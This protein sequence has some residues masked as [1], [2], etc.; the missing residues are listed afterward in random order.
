[1]KIVWGFCGY[2]FS[3]EVKMVEEKLTD[4]SKRVKLDVAEEQLS[5]KKKK[6]T[7]EEEEERE[8]VEEEENGGDEDEEEEDEEMRII[9]EEYKV[10]KKNAPFLYDVC[11]KHNLSSAAPLTCQW[12]PPKTQVESDYSAHELLLGTKRGESSAKCLSIVKAFLPNDSAELQVKEFDG[13]ELGGYANNVSK[14]NPMIEIVHDGDVNRARFMPSDYFI[15]A[16][17]MGLDIGVFKFDEMESK[18]KDDTCRP[19][20]KGVGHSEEGYGLDWSQRLQNYLLSCGMDGTFVWNVDRQ[21]VTNG[22]ITPV[23][24][25]NESAADCAWNPHQADTFATVSLDGRASF[26]DI[27]EK[28]CI[29]DI[30]SSMGDLN[31][32]SFNPRKEN[33]F[34]TG[35]ASKN[36]Q[37]WD[38]RKIGDKSAKDSKPQHEL[39]GHTGEIYGLQWAPF[40]ENILAS[41]GDDRRVML[42][43][44]ER[45]GR[46]QTAEEAEDGEPELLFIHGGH[47]SRV[48][49]VS[50]NPNDEWVLASVADNGED[51]DLQIWQPAEHIYNEEA[52]DDDEEDDDDLE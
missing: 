29:F 39:R 48:M 35:G 52:D 27:R 28:K 25:F 9:Q 11:L 5:K 14:L 45:I 41:C 44:L 12:L 47:C 24:T 36:I 6:L 21:S 18:P 34:V 43:D 23:M 2:N 50:W 20:I 17:R 32:I 31:A 42:W 30:K 26:Y 37:L 13:K 8:I 7:N 22:G 33:V 4:E 46:E 40:N 3:K 38:I 49:D 10:W 19:Y 15:V 1:V 16:T 51:G